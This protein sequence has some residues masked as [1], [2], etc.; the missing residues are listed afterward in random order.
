MASYPTE[1]DDGIIGTDYNETID[2]LGGNDLIFG[3]GGNDIVIGNSG[4]D[5]LNGGAGNDVLFG[6][7]GIDTAFYGFS[8]SGITASLK[9]GIAYTTKLGKGVDDDYL[10]QIENLSGS[11][12]QDWLTGD[13]SANVI[14]GNG[15]NDH[16]YGLGGNDT[17]Y[18]GDGADT[19]E[20]GA[21]ADYMDAGNGVKN[22]LTTLSYRGSSSYVVVNVQAGFGL[23]GDAQGDTFVNFDHVRA[24]KYND[25]VLGSSV[26]NFLWGED[27]NDTL[28][29]YAGNDHMWGD[30][31][32]DS[33]HGGDGNDS[34]YGGAGADY[35][36]G[37]AGLDTA[38]YNLAG[39]GVVVS[40]A[41][42][43]GTIGDAAGDTFN[44]IE[45]F[46]GTNFKDTA[47][48]GDA[49]ESLIG[50]GGNDVLRG[51]NGNDELSGGDGDDTIAGGNGNDSLLGNF[52]AD[53]LLGGSGADTFHFRGEGV[54]TAASRDTISDFISGTDKLDIYMDNDTSTPVYLADF[55]LIGSAAFTVGQ[56]GEIRWFT[57]G[58]STIVQA[59]NTGDGVADFEV[60][61]QN[62]ASITASDFLLY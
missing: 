1:F 32:T 62:T 3:G 44:S 43:S 41:T 6:G 26:A 22:I 13:D 54:S 50:W 7:I 40:F 30:N 15:G 20:G 10:F 27:G 11:Q 18:G 31:G 33:L 12:D 56:A 57:S 39:S 34:L 25:T 9:D 14:Y 52:G 42:G 4:D 55:D 58:G 16:I 29:G 2:G 24:S 23:F 46:S 47:N 28:Y 21:G 61:L 35:L 38:N 36:N 19:I 8:L 59:E 37:G 48:G 45:T 49:D 5:M 53:T 17:I 51:A 60:L